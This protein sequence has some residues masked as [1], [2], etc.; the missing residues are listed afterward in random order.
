MAYDV[1]IVFSGLCAYVPN[2]ALGAPADPPTRMRL[3]MP[4]LRVARK[5]GVHQVARHLP[6]LAIDPGFLAGGAGAATGSMA[7]LPI[8]RREISFAFQ[9]AAGIA[10]SID[11]SGPGT[12]FNRGPAMAEAAIEHAT[13]DA[14][15]LS[16]Q[17]PAVVTARVQVDAGHLAAH[18]PVKDDFYFRNE[19]QKLSAG[20]PRAHEISLHFRQ[21]TDFEIRS[22]DLNDAAS[23]ATPWL[24]VTAPAGSTAELEIGNLCDG[25]LMLYWD[26]KVPEIES[27]DDVD[28]AAYYLLSANAANVQ[29]GDFP[30]I[31]TEA[32]GG[33][34]TARCHDA[35]FKP[36]P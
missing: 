23:V 21:V 4:D 11:Q 12:N 30:P 36:V 14:A 3:V 31:L 26:P 25:D 8:A 5:V 35:I 28:F 17:P 32:A 20:H 24:R 27:L 33:G 19:T 2:K 16:P 22:R 29:P 15:C 1:K 34:K 7:V 10:L 13:I 18:K 9:S 6:V